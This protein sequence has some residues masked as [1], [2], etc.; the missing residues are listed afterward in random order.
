[1]EVDLQA[2]SGVAVAAALTD[3]AMFKEATS[4]SRVVA[5]SSKYLVYSL[6]NPATLRVL[7][8]ANNAQGTFKNHKNDVDVAK[9]VNYKSNVIATSAKDEFFVW[10]ITTGD[11][12]SLETKLYFSLTDA[13]TIRS[14]SWF[15]D[16]KSKT[17]ELLVLYGTTA[18]QFTSSRLITEY[19]GSPIEV[20]LARHA[21]PFDRS[22]TAEASLTTVGADGLFAFSVDATTVAVSTAR[23]GNAPPLRACDGEVLIG[24]EVLQDKPATM[25]AA[26]TRFVNVWSIDGEPSRLYKI[27]IGSPITLFLSSQNT[28]AIFGDNKELF[29][30]DVA[31]KKIQQS[32][33]HSLHYQVPSSL[34]SVTLSTTETGFASM[35]D[36]GSRLSIHTVK[37]SV[38]NPMSLASTS[39]SPAAHAGAPVSPA[40]VDPAIVS[41]APAAAGPTQRR[42][43]PQ[44]Q[45]PFT[46]PPAYFPAAAP[47]VAPLLVARAGLVANPTLPQVSQDGQIAQSLEIAQSELAEVRQR[48]DSAVQN[49]AQILQLVPQMVRRDHSSLLTLSLE[50]QMTE[51][52]NAAKAGELGIAGGAAAGATG[53]ESQLLATLM[54][55]TAKRLVEGLVPGIR[56]AILSEL[57]PSLRSAVVNHLKKSQKDVFKSRVDAM[58]KNVASEFVAALDRKQKVY[59][60]QFENY[61][62]EVR[63]VT[64]GALQKLLVHVNALEDQLLAITSS[65]ILDEVKALRSEVKSLRQDAAANV[66][67]ETS[68]S[69]VTIVATAKAM[70]ESREAERGLEYVVRINST[71]VTYS[72]LEEINKEDA[73]KDIALQVTNDRLWGEILLH[74]AS[75]TKS[76]QLPTALQWVKEIV[77]DHEN[78]LKAS[79]AVRKALSTFIGTWKQA[80][81][82]GAIDKEL[83]VIEKLI[84]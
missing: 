29:L 41:A 54:D 18:A 25:A 78:V 48:L 10:F 11:D 46:P 6:K 33:R 58:M 50:A 51:L 80:Q 64:E 67:P 20:S 82:E 56:D 83:R 55:D 24:L 15:L 59:E 47:V 1:M 43:P 40:M 32:T 57:E 65:G 28:I 76:S 61:G 23:H 63:R 84:R 9:F 30:V 72:L 4:R 60:K 44:P 27:T 19:Q 17:P 42:Q 35:S 66:A 81:L 7:A 34:R 68:L 77:T 5:D 26:C 8:R 3:V 45:M 39:G 52:Q 62:K 70:I 71:E 14:L 31:N 75:V 74:L 36:F 2:T 12:G 73:L 49:T 69:P 79:V 37:R 13:I 53:F 22:V 21:L 38:V 16:T